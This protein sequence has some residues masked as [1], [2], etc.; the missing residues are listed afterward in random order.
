[1]KQHRCS[2]AKAE[3]PE[4]ADTAMILIYRGYGCV[5]GFGF[6]I[7]TARLKT[8]GVIAYVGAS[9]YNSTIFA[10]VGSVEAYDLSLTP[11]GAVYS[12]D[13][14]QASPIVYSTS[15]PAMDYVYFTSNTSAPF[16]NVGG[17]YCYSFNGT[18][19]NQEW[20]ELG[21][22]GNTYAVQGFSSDGNCLVYGDDGN[23]L[24]VMLP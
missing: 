23:Y 5:A 17:G 20:V 8:G 3:E 2:C 14:V 16:G 15:R 11:L 13:P 12:G 10:M 9:E 18:A 1:M 6:L 24:Y 7:P 22:S 19:A 4:C 21:T